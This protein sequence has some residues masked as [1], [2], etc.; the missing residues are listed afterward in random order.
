MDYASALGG[1]NCV[2]T[3]ED[4]QRRLNFWNISAVVVILLYVA[5]TGTSAVLNAYA[6]TQWGAF[7][8]EFGNMADMFIQLSWV[9]FVV[10]AVIVSIW[11]YRAH[12]N[13]SVIGLDGLE[14]TPGWSIGWFFVPIASLV[15]P[16]R[17]MREL[18]ERSGAAADVRW[19]GILPYWW[20]TFLIGGVIENIGGRMI[21]DV[22]G[23]GTGILLLAIG[24]VTRVVCAV[25]LMQI[26]RTATRAEA[27]ASSVSVTF[28]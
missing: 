9:A 4:A 25:L 8:V 26:I 2:D 23:T 11:I 15:M 3:I 16:Y 6:A 22:S 21:S 5:V 13:L 20:G 28:A 7:T 18:W 1:D 12:A 27:T 17:A 14:F 24:Q 19:G 10:S